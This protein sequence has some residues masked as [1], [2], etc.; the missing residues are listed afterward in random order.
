MHIVRRYPGDSNPS[1]MGK[2]TEFCLEKSNLTNHHQ[3]KIDGN[4]CSQF[5][6]TQSYG[7]RVLS[8]EPNVYLK[9]PQDHNRDLEAA[10]RQKTWRG[11]RLPVLPI[12]FHKG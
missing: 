11:K 8:L 5:F 7:V 12:L 2:D 6:H 3:R 10:D 1:F 4:K 9:C